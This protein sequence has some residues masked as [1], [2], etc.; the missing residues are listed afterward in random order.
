MTKS[1][2]PHWL[3]RLD[4]TTKTRWRRLRPRVYG[5]TRWTAR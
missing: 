3:H 5:P 2:D 4:I 1:L